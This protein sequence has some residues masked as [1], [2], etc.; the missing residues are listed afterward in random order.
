MCSTANIACGVSWAFACVVVAGV[1]VRA[2]WSAAVVKVG[3][4][5]GSG[6]SVVGSTRVWP[7]AA[8][9]P[10]VSTNALA[11]RIPITAATMMASAVSNRLRHNGV[12]NPPPTP[13]GCGRR[14]PGGV[15][16]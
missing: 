8:W 10:L 2:V 13:A 15:L 16:G 9:L 5:V 12:M 3:G 11:T 7:T 14:P 4:T 1:V 6:W